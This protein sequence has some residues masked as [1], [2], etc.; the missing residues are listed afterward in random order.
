MCKYMHYIAEY[1]YIYI[2]LLLSSLLLLLLLLLSLSL[3]LLVVFV[4]G[5]DCIALHYGALY[6]LTF[7]YISL[8]SI[9]SYYKYI[10]IYIYNYSY[11]LS[12]IDMCIHSYTDLT[13]GLNMVCF[14][15]IYTCI[16]VH[17]CIHIYTQSCSKRWA[18]DID[19]FLGLSR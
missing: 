15:S 6:C 5:C 3:L 11:S 7:H 2:L 9:A 8:G 18:A 10:D 17:M 19:I 12:G 14:T 16:H 4:C 13:F 1:L